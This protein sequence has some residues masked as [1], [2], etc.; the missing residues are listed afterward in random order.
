DGMILIAGSGSNGLNSYVLVLRYGANGVLDITFNATGI[1]TFRKKAN[2]ADAG[3]AVAVQS[4]GSIVVIGQTSLGADNDLLALRYKS[5]GTRDASFSGDGVALFGG[6]AGGEDIGRAVALQANG[7]IVVVGQTSDGGNNDVLVL[8]Y[9]SDGTLDTGFNGDGAAVFNGTANN[10]DIGRAVAIQPDGKIVEV[11]QT[12]NGTNNNLLVL[13]YDSNGSLDSTFG[14]GGV[15]TFGGSAGTTGRAVA[16]QPDGMIVAAG[17]TSNGTDSDLLL[18]R[19]DANGF[20]DAAFGAGG[21]VIYDSGSDDAARAVALQPDGKI[22]VTGF[23]NNGTKNIALIMRF[24]AN[25]SL[26]STFG[27]DGIIKHN[28]GGAG[29]DIGNA[30]AVQADNKIVVTGITDG[31]DVL[32]LRY[33][34]DGTPDPV[35]AFSDQGVVTFSRSAAGDAGNALVL[36]SDGKIV[37]AGVSD[38]DVLVLRFIGQKLKLL[39]PNGGEKLAANSSFNIEWTSPPKAVLFTIQLSLDNGVT[40][41]TIAAGVAAS[42]YAWTVPTPLGTKTQCLVRVKSFDVDNAKVDS[43]QSNAVFTIEPVTLTAP[44]GGELFT[45]G[46]PVTITWATHATK[47]PVASVKLAYTFNGGTTWNPIDTTADPSD[48]GSFSWTAPS[49]TAVKKTKV[50][51]VLK[52]SAGKTLGSDASD[53]VFRISP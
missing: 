41:S 36:Q 52:D 9:K 25:G 20:P 53:A 18:V 24:T 44:N 27:G 46:A 32:L 6:A 51:V 48:D 33:N 47:N 16:I 39:A 30:V 13:R 19:F 31:R 23:R 12:F 17:V 8:R 29:D 11:G 37:V 49:V 42:P 22:V 28:S 4:D 21:A 40:W 38:S 14:T 34:A 10:E 2:T 1:V 50:K 15:A 3:N 5:D 7:K 45:S 35:G 26:D 43:D